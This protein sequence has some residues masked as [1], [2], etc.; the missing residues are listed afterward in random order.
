MATTL[1]P[2][3]IRMPGT[4]FTVGT[5]W[6][7]PVLDRRD[8]TETHTS[9][10]PLVQGLKI[11]ANGKGALAPALP[12]TVD[13]RPW[14]SPIEN[15]Q[16]LGS[17]TAHAAV[18]I[19]EYYENKAFKKYLDGSRLFVYKNTRNLMG[20]TGDTGAWLRDT[21]G[22]L[23]M[24]GVAEEKFWP[25]TDADPAFDQDPT[26]FIYAIADNFESLKYFC[27]D[28][29]GQNV[30]FPQVLASVKKYLVAG[31]PSMFGFWG[32]QSSMSSNVPGA[33]AMPGPT[34]PIQW[35]HA[36]AAV[37]YDDNLKIT[38]TQNNLTS[39]GALLIRN[40][41]GEDFGTQGYGWIPYDYVLKGIATDFWSLLKME[42]VNTKEFQFGNSEAQAE[43]ARAAGR[44]KGRAVKPAKGQAAQSI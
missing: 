3:L 15:Q 23:V 32:Y 16:N 33:F 11:P 29:L 18:G 2:K 19:V 31:V 44:S 25:Y 6:I 10:Q 21:M 28:P 13:L 37:G 27:H 35:G 12:A 38:N 34:E 39:K 9:V 5:G 7:P 40:S 24:C 41:W 26:P 4:N 17:C 1:K 30:P 8:Y 42:W 43:P 14:C 36:V 22:S 20:V